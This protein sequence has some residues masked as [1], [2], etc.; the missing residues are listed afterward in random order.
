VNTHSNIVASGARVLLSIVLLAT[1]ITGLKTPIFGGFALGTLLE[2]VKGLYQTARG[3]DVRMATTLRLD[4]LSDNVEVL[5]DHRGVPH[6]YAQN[7]QD[8]VTA[9]GY[10]VARDRLFELDFIPRAAAGR[11]S[12]IMGSSAISTDRH[13]RSIGLEWASRK[14]ADDHMEAI[15]WFQ[16]GANAYI[17]SL[18]ESDYPFE[19]RLMGYKPKL[20]KPIDAL[21]LQQYMTY[22][23][24]YQGPN[25]HYNEL[26]DRLGDTEF[27][28][29][30]P[31]FS[32]YFEPIIPPAE[33]HW[34]GG[35]GRVSTVAGNSGPAIIISGLAATEHFA[36][37]VA[38]G[39]RDGIGSNN[40]AVSGSRSETGFPILAGDMHLNLSLPSIWY[41]AHLVSPDMN[42]YGVTF[43]GT[44]GIVEGITPTT[45]WTYTNTGAD[46]IDH[47]LLDVDSSGTK[48]RV[49]NVWESF[50]MQSDTIFVA[51]ADPVVEIR[52]YSIYGPV[53][54]DGE[55]YTAIRWVA[56]ERSS[57]MEAIWE[58]GHSAWYKDFDRATRKWGSPMQ[59]ILFASRSD[60]VSIRSTGF[61]PDRAGSTGLGLL[62]GMSGSNY[63]KGRVSFEDL[64]V[65]INPEQGFLTSTNQQPADSTYPYY[66]GSNWVS[67]HRSLRINELLSGTAK[68]SVSDIKAYQSD[69][70][71]VQADQLIPFIQELGGLSP[72]AE[73]IQ[74]KLVD[75]DRM[76]SLDQIEPTLFRFF[77]DELEGAMW[78]EP[79]FNGLRRP[80]FS[81]LYHLLLTDSTSHWFDVQGTSKNESGSD[82]VRI[83]LERTGVKYARQIRTN[84]AYLTWK[85][86]H[87]ILFRHLTRSPALRPL[88]RGDYPYPGFTETLSPGGSRIT[89]HSA[90]WRVVVDFSAI[91]PNA[92]GVYPGGQ[93]GNPFSERYDGQIDTYLSFEYYP[94]ILAR[95]P[96][97]FPPGSLWSTSIL[98]PVN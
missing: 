33:A 57:T 27:R 20:L 4:G 52:L 73:L 76:A 72:D 74:D 13:F 75:W 35:T 40:W 88:W 55:T 5:Y 83:I 10:V 25:S 82:L 65:S 62:D 68:H 6:I 77:L 94:L 93:S 66:L 89:T 43:P 58:M 53:L 60:T 44:P 38:E 34:S 22:D 54:T 97:E 3:A 14:Y 18:S 45:A 61:L 91:P 17:S 23:L 7:D 81:T 37:T 48:Y 90:S 50:E 47:Y 85:N 96:Q 1:V 98:S 30:F 21:L 29:L 32:R 67:T 79:V 12:E 92:F 59:N 87:R 42:V 95:S 11:L 39:Y 86:E 31:P 63:W 71:I 51:D 49:G 41:E 24:S 15:D 69:V 80:E 2:P 19:M 64:P 78:D 56:H 8:L 16:A 84:P 36:G 70:F 28:R 9:F 26:R 46:Q